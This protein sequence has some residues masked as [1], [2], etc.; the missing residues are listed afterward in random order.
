MKV[1]RFYPVSALRRLEGL[2]LL[3][4][5]V[6]QHAAL[7]YAM[8]RARRLGLDIRVV[9]QDLR[10]LYELSP[11]EAVAFISEGASRVALRVLPSG[12]G[13]LRARRKL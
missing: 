4:M 7:N 1:R 6:G 5:S 3:Q 2:S 12:D 10:K 9:E 8:R 11:A 13:R